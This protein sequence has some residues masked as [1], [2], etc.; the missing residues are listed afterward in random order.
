MSKN[1][2]EQFMI[3][4]KLKIGQEFS[5]KGLPSCYKSEGYY[6]DENY[7]LLL[8]SCPS[9]RANQLIDI[10][11]DLLN[12]KLQVEFKPFS[13]Q[14]LPKHGEKFWSV[15]IECIDYHCFALNVCHYALV[16]SG[17]AFHTEEEAEANAPRIRKEQGM[18]K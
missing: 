13:P 17:N 16:A 12:G 1:Y 5:I 10:L 18:I 8:K 15:G 14:N 9:F 2:I 6:F 7:N 3:D 11:I 4:N